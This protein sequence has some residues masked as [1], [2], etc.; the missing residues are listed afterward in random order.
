M[1]PPIKRQRLSAPELAGRSVAHEEFDEYYELSNDGHTDLDIDP[2]Q[3]IYEIEDQSEDEEDRD[4]ELQQK[5]AVVHN[6]LKSRFEAI[7]E[8]Y[9]KDFTGIG[10][11][12]DLSTG[13]IV[14]NN[15][16]LIDMQDERD[17]GS[18]HRRLSGAFTQE[19]EDNIAT[20]DDGP[21]SLQDTDGNVDSDGHNEF[22]HTASGNMNDDMGLYQNGTAASQ[23]Q[24]SPSGGRSAFVTREEH[25]ESQMIPIAQKP[26]PSEA[27]ILAQFGPQLG[28]QISRYVSQQCVLDNASIDP[29]WR[30]PGPPPVALAKTPLLKS[31]LLQPT[32]IRVTSG[33][34]PGAWPA[35]K[36]VLESLD[37][38]D[39]SPS[40]EGS[41]SIW[42]VKMPPGRP[43]KDGAD[44]AAIFKGE[45]FRRDGAWYST[46][47]LSKHR[48]FNIQRQ[49]GARVPQSSREGS[50]KGSCEAED[51]TVSEAKA[52]RRPR[53]DRS[54]LSGT[55]HR[56]ILCE[57]SQTPPKAK[58]HYSKPKK[59]RKPRQSFTPEEDDLV[60]EW[61]EEAQRRGYSLWGWAHWKIFA[62]SVSLDILKT[63]YQAKCIEQTTHIFI[64]ARSLPK[65]YLS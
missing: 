62:E 5:R 41:S 14:V 35:S 12:I 10:D 19:P 45:I 13:E 57:E 40:P 58:R 47:A 4:I 16:H 61:V 8:K 7:F 25:Q 46:K 6:K 50:V 20:M 42:A 36:P 55:R 3:G 30:V 11:E 64:L 27:A 54:P 29:L 26:Y 51:A 28:P 15:G 31:M 53:A 33:K 39:R 18:N 63:W 17:A 37:E 60:I 48:A 9:G 49:G 43:R 22:E 2:S 32:E 34:T 59:P 52:K 44:V 38:S 21:E 65:T 23:R 24:N 1:E 56:V